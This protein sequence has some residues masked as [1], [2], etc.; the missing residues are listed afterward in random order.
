MARKRTQPI[1]NEY[2]LKNRMN[3]VLSAY[4]TA[5]QN[6][7][8]KA[9]VSATKLLSDATQSNEFHL[10]VAMF[11]RN[12]ISNVIGNEAI[13]G[14]ALEMLSPYEVQRKKDVFGSNEKIAEVY[15][16]LSTKDSSGQNFFDKMLSPGSVKRDVSLDWQNMAGYQSHQTAR[17]AMQ[18]IESAKQ[19]GMVAWD[20]ETTAGKVLGEDTYAS[21]V[22]EFSFA[23]KKVGNKASSTQWFNSIIGATDAEYK[24]Y[25]ELVDKV[26]NNA[27][28]TP[29]ETITAQRLA[30]AGHHKSVAQFKDGSWTYSSFAGADDIKHLD[31]TLVQRGADSMYDIGKHQRANLV[32]ATIGGQA[33]AGITSYE[34]KLLRGLDTI[35]HG[36]ATALGF[37]SRTFDMS[38]L[39][40]L[41]ADRDKISDQV[42]GAIYNWFGGDTFKFDNHL[43]LMPVLREKFDKSQY[44]AADYNEMRKH[45]LTEFQ[46]E[47]LVRKLT[48]KSGQLFAG[49]NYYDQKGLVAH[50]AKTDVGA[51]VELAEKTVF[52]GSKGNTYLY[53][54]NDV[55]Q[56]VSLQGT[57]SKGNSQ[58]F[59]AKQRVNE[60]RYNLLVG[61]KDALSG[62][63]RFG[64]KMAI[65]ESGTAREQ[66]FG[67]TG[68]QRGVTY[69]VNRLYEIDNTMRDTLKELYPQMA[70][71][72][73]TVMEMQAY[74]GGKSNT[75]RANSPIYYVGYREDIE[76]MMQDNALYIGDI[77]AN[78]QVTGKMDQRTLGELRTFENVNTTAGISV[79]KYSNADVPQI[80]EHGATRSQEDA[81]SRYIRYKD[82]QKDFNLVRLMQAIDDA[83]ATGVAGGNIARIEEEFFNNSIKVSKG[84]LSG[85]PINVNSD[86]FKYSYNAYI[87]YTDP[88]SHEQGKL[89]SET[90]SAQRARLGWARKNKDLLTYALNKAEAIGNGDRDKAT[91]AYQRIMQGV[92]DYVKANGTLDMLGY[93]NTSVMGYEYLNKFDV[94]LRGFRGI[95]EDKIITL[96]MDAFGSSM[97]NQII[98]GIDDG[99]IPS[100]YT[101]TGKSKV[102]KELQEHL[103]KQGVLTRSSSQI[104]YD[105]TLDLAGRKFSAALTEA[106]KQNVDIGHLVDPDTGTIRGMSRIGL[107]T[108]KDLG[109]GQNGLASVK[110]VVDNLSRNISGYAGQFSTK[111]V[112]IAATADKLS[113]EAANMMFRESDIDE[114]EKLDVGYTQKE[115]D[116]LRRTRARLYTDAKDYLNNLFQQI[117]SMGGTV[118][119][120]S[121]AR[122]AF[123]H[124]G[125]KTVE[126]ELPTGEVRGGQYQTRLGSMNVSL[127]VGLYDMRKFGE[128]KAEIQYASLIR[129]AF[130]QNKN[131][132]GW[133]K[134]QALR[135]GNVIEHIQR[136]T[137]QVNSVLRKAPAVKEFG[138]VQR[139]NQFL[140]NYWDVLI[141]AGQFITKEDMDTIKE[142]IRLNGNLTPGQKAE[143]TLSYNILEELRTGKRKINPDAPGMPEL[144]A[145]YKHLDVIMN[146]VMSRGIDA[147]GKEAYNDVRLNIKS[148]A[149]GYAYMTDYGDFTHGFNQQKRHPIPI[150]DA[151]HL[152]FTRINEYIQRGEAGDKE[153]SGLKDITAGA[154]LTQES[155][156]KWATYADGLVDEHGNK[157]Q[158]DTRAR[159]NALHMNRGGLA[160]VVNEGLNQ[161]IVQSASSPDKL[162]QIGK[163]GDLLR[164]MFIDEGT[165]YMHGQVFDR[166]MNVRDSIQ[167]LSLDK[168][169]MSDGLTINEIKAKSST[170]PKVQIDPNGKISFTYDT[171]LF[172][173]QDDIIGSVKGMSGDARPERAKYDGVLN[174]GLFDNE[175]HLIE[176]DRITDL[177]NNDAQLKSRLQTL[178]NNERAKAIMDYLEKDKKF[179]WSYYVQEGWANPLVKVAEFSEKGM[180]RGLIANTGQLNS[181]IKEVMEE[182]GFQ[183]KIGDLTY[184]GRDGKYRALTQIDALEIGMIDSLQG[185]FSK[186]RFAVEAVGRLERLGKHKDADYVKDIIEKKFGSVAQFRKELIEERYA[187]SKVLTE[188]FRNTKFNGES[189]LG[190]DEVWHIITGHMQSGL[191]KHGDVT[192][193][194][195]L[196]D[197]WIK[198]GLENANGA[199]KAGMA[200]ARDNVIKYILPEEYQKMNPDDVIKISGDKL[201]LSDDAAKN[202]NYL[203]YDKLQQAYKDTGIV[204]QNGNFVGEKTLAFS[205]GDA[206]ARQEVLIEKIRSEI[207]RVGHYWD[208][209]KTTGDAVRFN[210][211]AITIAENTRVGDMGKE[212]VRQFLA[213]SGREHLF[214]KYVAGLQ[215]GEAVLSSAVDQ[216]KKNMFNR[217][218]GG[219]NISG[220]FK[221]V[222]GDALEWGID[223]GALEKLVREENIGNGNVDFGKTL[224]TNLMSSMRDKMGVTTVNRAGAVEAYKAFSAT[225]AASYLTGQTSLEDL[226]KLGF[227]ELTIGNIDTSSHS[228]DTLF[229]QNVVVN[230]DTGNPE[231]NDAL[232]GSDRRRQYLALSY[233]PVGDSER[234]T[235]AQAKVASLQNKILEFTKRQQSGDWEGTSGRERELVKLSEALNEARDATWNAYH[236]KKG[237]VANALRAH[238]QGGSRQTASGFDILGIEKFKNQDADLV[239]LF[240]QHG[241]SQ[242]SKFEINGINLLEEAKR[243]KQAI[244]FNYSIMSMQQMHNIYDTELGS[245]MDQLGLSSQQRGELVSSLETELTTKG[246]HGISAREPMQYF[247]SV[248]QRQI[249]FSSIASGN[250]VI[251]NFT[252]SVMRKEDFDSDAIVNAIHREQAAIEFNGKIINANI[253]SAMMN[254]LRDKGMKVTLLDEGGEAR[255]KGYE[256]AQMYIGAGEAQRYRE[257]IDMAQDNVHVPDDSSIIRVAA[258]NTLKVQEFKQKYGEVYLDPT[259]N[260][261]VTG[262]KSNWTVQ[263]MK[264]LET[265]YYDTARKLFQ[266]DSSFMNMN[267]MQRRA[268]MIEYAEG[269][270]GQAQTDVM[271]AVKYSL[272]SETLA[273]DLM[274][275]TAQP[276]GAGIVNHYAQTY[277]NIANEA[278]ND[279]GVKDF[280]SKSGKDAGLIME[281]IQLVSTAI[282]E[283]FLSPKNNT[284]EVDTQVLSKMFNKVFSM[285]DNASY[286]TREKIKQE[287]YDTIYGG[288][289]NERNDKET[290]RAMTAFVDGLPQ[291]ADLKANAQ[292]AV[293]NYVNF[294][295]DEVAMRGNDK[296]TYGMAT[297]GNQNFKFGFKVERAATSDRVS[298]NFLGAA[299]QTASMMDVYNLVA[300]RESATFRQRE[301]LRDDAGGDVRRNE[302]RIARAKSMQKEIGAAAEG[303]LR[304]LRGNGILGMTL[305]IAGGLMV[306]GFVHDPSGGPRD[307]PTAEG[308]SFGNT[309]TPNSGVPDPAV[310]QAQSGAQYMSAM[311]M[312]LADANLNVLR[313]GPKSSYV[314]NIT[315][316]SPEGQQSAI[317]AINSAI[318]GPI[319]HNSSINVAVNNNYQDTL[320]QMQVNRMVQTAIGF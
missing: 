133:H 113:T 33:F 96:N 178:D 1:N 128:E 140:F 157:I 218:G 224:M 17:Q 195:Y 155:R 13:V 68:V 94:N 249:F 272:A 29:E 284:R 7:A 199:P 146:R 269:L 289:V 54:T 141:N 292:R 196:V 73:L 149:K 210:Q 238:M 148:S 264:N 42:R 147:E 22:T 168:M 51:V 27:R 173:T 116:T 78:G 190:Q 159:V 21:H 276:Y 26:R 88:K 2:A 122:K 169:I 262:K 11:N 216:I 135:D 120:D 305:G 15:G 243:G 127:S 20:L 220:Y 64:D 75:V 228:M 35:A 131:L 163:T 82:Y 105:D 52:D 255:M 318:S 232:F 153:F 118:T 309:P 261:Y 60:G 167:K 57:D 106:R 257:L 12:A 3:Q 137:G 130:E 110:D 194:R 244:Q 207:S 192:H 248:Q 40:Q 308:A 150:E 44:T 221:N 18:A 320:N 142:H 229:N 310:D 95:N 97:A 271:D 59:M 234:F 151:S 91:F 138:E 58:L 47:T 6:A 28:L 222:A 236:S 164:T 161:L 297:S 121:G 172:V 93:E 273:G 39:N 8:T 237:V 241:G 306:A 287:F 179:N 301:A 267:G 294:M 242:I 89:Y 16:K 296:S 290:S 198:R 231:L 154:G 4:D 84:L 66:L 197:E 14:V 260:S 70:I 193:Y 72:K 38:R 208:R 69:K 81:A 104:T 259:T 213:G 43:D 203:Q 32:N 5:V 166:L 217:A 227:T 185:E 98:R 87:G 205:I 134:R 202:I 126:L 280:F 188:A 270:S 239:D 65:D 48:S 189:V 125:D 211:R 103:Y 165:A 62:E 25:N 206:T 316:S 282:Q 175:G 223:T 152:D 41:I 274:A 114:L 67:Q 293:H 102:L 61:M 76:H 258:D 186:S 304:H 256:S 119:V 115:L 214:N 171:G 295:I 230:F 160:A 174:F 9:G 123:A 312:P 56:A 281:D 265:T 71:D 50:L 143:E 63:L 246:T 251:G 253:D 283:G 288:I 191:K 132:I 209:E 129:K 219:E 74:T 177:L 158:T 286:E 254:V 300:E 278:L 315:G 170:V 245:I 240:N 36:Q 268:K 145:V 156:D 92:E 277:L 53:N 99:S 291:G 77:D 233:N 107:N 109:L 19:H 139:A 212:N 215:S 204:D 201:I 176:Q 112:D 124:A 180:T 313:G 30:L 266:Q 144:N 225:A 252:G 10:G 86:T 79:T 235:A 90:L 80:I 117:G 49:D 314:I 226:K 182:L 181:K 302:E 275:R 317:N 162:A 101:D 45:G 46:Q 55:N 184:K 285:P 23:H 24:E 34:E 200:W 279:T 83:Q 303:A 247:G 311:Q 136:M 250:Q 307:V 85:N 108:A 187:P 111:A 298:D 100:D 319:P 31:W 263:E 299:D 183:G 37:N